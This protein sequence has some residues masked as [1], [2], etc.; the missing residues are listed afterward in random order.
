[1]FFYLKK[2]TELFFT[3]KKAELFFFSFFNE[4][5]EGSGESSPA[6]YML[7]KKSN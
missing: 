4:K 2:K 6:G 1:L 3:P 5:Q 7:E